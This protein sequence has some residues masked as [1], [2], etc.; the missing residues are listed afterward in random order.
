MPLSIERASRLALRDAT[1]REEE[2]MVI[3]VQGDLILLVNYS[4]SSAR[5]YRVAVSALCNHSS[6]FATLLDSTKFSEGIAVQSRLADLRS[7]HTDIASVPHVDLPRVTISDVFVGPRSSHGSLPDSAFH[8]FLEILHGRLEWSISKKTVRQPDFLALLVHYAEA[9]GAVPRVSQCIKTQVKNLLLS[10]LE[11]RPNGVKEEKARQ[12]LYIG[13]T[14]GFPLWVQI[15][16][17]SL[18]IHGSYQWSE[19]HDSGQGSGSEDFPW[20][21]LSGGVEGQQSASPRDTLTKTWQKNSSIA[22]DGC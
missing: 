8:L 22:D 21:Y 5:H 12:K 3:D 19:A 6:Y 2:P 20:E 10:D 16:S 14:L 17:A 7:L 4:E 15:Y 18:I 1:S 11:Q 9:F 13:L